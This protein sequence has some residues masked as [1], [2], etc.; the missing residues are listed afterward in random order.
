M[1]ARGHLLFANLLSLVP[2]VFE[3]RVRQ[4]SRLARVIHEELQ[5][6]VPRPLPGRS[7]SRQ[8]G[9]SL[10]IVGQA[11]VTARPAMEEQTQVSAL[12][13]RCQQ[14]HPRRGEISIDPDRHEWQFRRHVRAPS[15]SPDT[16]RF[17]SHVVSRFQRSAS[18][19]SSTPLTSPFP[20][21]QTALGTQPLRIVA[22][23]CS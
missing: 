2:G 7:E 6:V 19:E 3:D 22:S 8:R 17:R 13:G 5:H 15:P 23:H 4:E 18:S 16:R 20:G 12:L 10:V 14:K 21:V 9:E 1:S 11:G